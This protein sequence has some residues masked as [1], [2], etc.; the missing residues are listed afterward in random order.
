VEGRLVSILGLA[1]GTL[2]MG[3]SR[4]SPGRTGEGLGEGTGSGIPGRW[5]FGHGRLDDGADRVGSQVSK[6]G[7]LVVDHSTDHGHQ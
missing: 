5:F 4:L 1:G 7:H 3:G 6:V 2:T